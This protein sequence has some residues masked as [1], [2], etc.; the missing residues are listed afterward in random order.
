M[1]KGGKR[2][3]W[4][5]RA[6]KINHNIEYYG[7]SIITRRL[8]FIKRAFF[9]RIPARPIAIGL[10]TL[11]YFQPGPIWNFFIWRIE[12]PDVERALS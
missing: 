5:C 10:I 1:V 12:I 2:M 7:L 4:A 11:Q 9:W 6:G 3:P 8:I